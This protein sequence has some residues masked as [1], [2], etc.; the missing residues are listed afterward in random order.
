[1]LSVRPPNGIRR[2][3]NEVSPSFGSVKEANTSPS[4]ELVSVRGLAQVFTQKQIKERIIDNVVF[5]VNK[6]FF[7]ML[8]FF[9]GI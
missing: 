4:V 8:Y 1:M 5:W 3:R 2:E 7:F 6:P 9:F